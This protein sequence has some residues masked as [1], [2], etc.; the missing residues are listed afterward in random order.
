VFPERSSVW[1]TRLLG[2]PYWIWSDLKRWDRTWRDPRNAAWS[3]WNDVRQADYLYRLVRQFR[4]SVVVETGVHFGKSSVVI[5]AALQRNGRGRL[6]S[7]DLPTAAS[8]DE[9]GHLV[10]PELRGRWSLRLGDTRTHLPAALEGGV[11]FFFHDSEHTYE[12]QTFEYEVAWPALE[13][14]GVFVSDDTNRST[15]WAEFLERH[16]GAWRPLP[17]GPTSVRAVRKVG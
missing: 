16:R 15:A 5:L 10:P 14:G 4:P 3:F 6:V 2:D 11:Q 17:D 8:P 1:P 12:H 13:P 7:I 9:T